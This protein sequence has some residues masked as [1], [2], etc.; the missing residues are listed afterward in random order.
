LAPAP[1]TD[2]ALT[3][4][5]TTRRVVFLEPQS[6]RSQWL[7][8]VRGAPH[9]PLALLRSLCLGRPVRRGHAVRRVHGRHC[10]VTRVGARKAGSRPD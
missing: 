8:A 6:A 3:A 2:V 1:T 10:P 9:L 7:E 5:N 4:A